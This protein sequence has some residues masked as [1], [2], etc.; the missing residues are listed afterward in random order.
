MINHWIFKCKDVSHLI[1][2]SMDQKL[3]LRIRFGVKFHL[4][5]CDLCLRYKEQ[6]ELIGKSISKIKVEEK[7][8][9]SFRHLPDQVKNRIKK[10]LENS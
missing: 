6:L 8:N 5:M 7:D 4:M 1:S 9:Y 10:H 2:R 3:P